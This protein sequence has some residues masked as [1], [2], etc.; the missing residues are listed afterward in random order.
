MIL[1]EESFCSIVYANTE[2]FLA[3]IEFIKDCSVIKNNHI[4][5][6]NTVLV[7]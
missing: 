2:S 3:E 1:M 7:K 4:N 5:S 6:R